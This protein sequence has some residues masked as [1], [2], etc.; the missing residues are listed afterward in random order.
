MTRRRSW[1]PA[2]DWIR[3][4][5]VVPPVLYSRAAVH[6]MRRRQSHLSLI[7][8]WCHQHFTPRRRRYEILI[9]K[10]GDHLDIWRRWDY[11]TA[12]LWLKLWA[13]HTLSSF[14][15]PALQNRLTDWPVCDAA[16]AG[17]DF[18]REELSRRAQPHGQV[19]GE[20]FVLLYLDFFL[21]RP[22][23]STFSAIPFETRGRKSS[24]DLTRKNGTTGRPQQDHIRR[25]YKDREEGA[26]TLAQ[27]GIMQT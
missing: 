10:I 16:K 17:R 2:E 13:K 15:S 20:A 18:P 5:R 22:R 26:A 27:E 25:I 19:G 23:I 21:F 9:W 7:T 4:K 3:R 1:M 6:R 14:S 24:L 11:R 8:L 12:A